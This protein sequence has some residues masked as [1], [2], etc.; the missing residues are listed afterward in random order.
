MAQRVPRA[1]CARR[2]TVIAE[3]DAVPALLPAWRP[4][5][6][7]RSPAAACGRRCPRAA[8]L[9]SPEQPPPTPAIHPRPPD[10]GRHSME[11]TMTL[12]T[13]RHDVP[14]SYWRWKNCSPTEIA[15]RGTGRLLIN[16]WALDALQA[17]RDRLGKPLILRSA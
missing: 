12:Y 9:P 17:L 14:A 13:H 11:N 2:R 16:E 4:A 3:V 6:T 10:A 7:G 1:A 8:H 5:T 15:C